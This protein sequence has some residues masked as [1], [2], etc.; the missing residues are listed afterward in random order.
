MH[1]DKRHVAKVKQTEK[2]VQ[3]SNICIN[4]LLLSGKANCGTSYILNLF[5]TKEASPCKL[6]CSEKKKDCFICLP[7]TILD[8]KVPGSTCIIPKTT[9]TVNT[10][11]WI[12]VLL[13]G[14][15]CC[16]LILLSFN[17]PT[18]HTDAIQDEIILASF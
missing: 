11:R 10:C 7:E 15:K 4:K 12:Y 17:H 13:N 14:S 2:S 1:S 16:K 18:I 3:Q 6:N 5:E 8:A 9:F